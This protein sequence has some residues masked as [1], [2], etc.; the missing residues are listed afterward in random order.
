MLVQAS[1]TSNRVW[2]DRLMGGGGLGEISSAAQQSKHL[3]LHPSHSKVVDTTLHSCFAW[4]LPLPACA[5][6]A[7]QLLSRTGGCVLV[8]GAMP[9]HRASSRS[10]VL[11]QHAM[12][13]CRLFHPVVI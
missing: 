12:L 1:I 3:L 8:A 4:R 13:L 6:Q 9:S 7:G 10:N 11:C 5:R 2:L